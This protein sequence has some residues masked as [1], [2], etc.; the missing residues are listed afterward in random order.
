[1]GFAG[2]IRIS[3]RPALAFV[4][5]GIIWAA[6][7]AQVPVLMAQVSASDSEFGMVFFIASMGAMLAMWLAPKADKVLGP[8]SVMVSCMV[9]GASIV[10]PSVA[11]S[12]V[13]FTVGMFIMA[14]ASGVTDVLMNA[15]IAEIEETSGRPLMNL[16]HAIFSFAYGGAA[17]L[18]GV[19]RDAGW[20]PG[21]VAVAVVVVITGLS[22]GTRIAP[23]PVEE[24]AAGTTPAGWRPAPIV[25]LLSGVVLAGFFTEHAVEGW[26]ALHL[27][28]G[29]GGDATA[30]ALGPAILGL[31]MGVGRL[32][33]QV[34]VRYLRDTAM[35]GVASLMSAAGL[36]L[37]A[38][39]GSL[40]MAYLGFALTGLGVSVLIPL[41]MAVIGR[42][43]PPSR[44]VASIGQASAI[45]Y[46]SFVVGPPVM[47]GVAELYGLPMAFLLAAACLVLV[48]AVLVPMIAA[49]LA[50][51]GAARVR[52]SRP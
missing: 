17:L 38:L 28:R 15:R 24:E 26:S 40:Y 48:S 5:M 52:S 23:K 49:H 6:F 42:S 2:D 9:M 43:V 25:L 44:R 8:M 19:A 31:T 51:A 36:A 33:G 7:S 46:A 22:L 30:G 37:A 14:S 3:V 45:G 32:F 16:N 29:L 34:L 50:Q 18:T 39:G 35:I 11:G 47:G 12:L 41:A 4:A 1:M 27:E 13:V 20:G 10:L 21:T